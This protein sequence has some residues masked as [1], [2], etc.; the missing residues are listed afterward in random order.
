M[1]LQTSDYQIFTDKST[2]SGGYRYFFN[3]QEDDNEV[4]GEVANYTAE[5]W[6]YDSRLGRRWNIDPVFKAYESP[7]ACFAGNPIDKSMLNEIEKGAIIGGETFGQGEK[8]TGNIYISI[9]AGNDDFV[10]H[11]NRHINRRL[12]STQNRPVLEV[13][14]EAYLYQKIYNPNTCSADNS[15]CLEKSTP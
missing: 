6:Q 12:H 11:E 2:N 5:F 7:Y 15:G 9:A 3:G 4:F 13:E 14:K 8:M 10:I 1:T